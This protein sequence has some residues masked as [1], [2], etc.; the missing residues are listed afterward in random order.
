MEYTLTYVNQFK[1]NK[2]GKPYIDKKGRPFVRVSIKVQEYGDNYVSGIIFEP[3]CNWQVGEKK[4]LVISKEMYS[5]K[6]QLKFELP[7]KENKFEKI[8]NDITALKLRV[9]NLEAR[10]APKPPK[11]PKGEPE[12]VAF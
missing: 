8:E 7:R 5:G 11:Y 10:L 6:E 12:E 9:S 4:E 1:T 2:E 3:N